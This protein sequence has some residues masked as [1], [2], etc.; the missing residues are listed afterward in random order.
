LASQATTVLVG[1]EKQL[2]LPGTSALK[3]KNY[4]NIFVQEPG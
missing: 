2:V 1:G 4:I 3:H